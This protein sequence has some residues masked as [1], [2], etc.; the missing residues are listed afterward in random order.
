MRR[1]TL[2]GAQAGGAINAGARRH[3]AGA[4]SVW[5]ALFALYLLSGCAI[6]PAADR[7]FLSLAMENGLLH[8]ADPRITAL[9]LSALLQAELMDRFLFCQQESI[10]DEE[11]RQVTAR[12]VEVFMAAYLPR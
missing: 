3:Y 12:A 9:H 5:S 8:R 2:R 7:R 4:E 10:D 6:Q 11:V 1:R